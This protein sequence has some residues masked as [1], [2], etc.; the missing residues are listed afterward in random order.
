MTA[1]RQFADHLIAS[2]RDRYG[3]RET[4][5]FVSQLDLATGTLPPA[6]SRFYAGEA[7]RGGAGPT[8]NNLQFDNGLIRLLDALTELGHGERYREAMKAYLDYYFKNL[9]D[10]KTG[11]LPWS[12]HQG[13]AGNQN[14][15]HVAT[16]HGHIPDSWLMRTPRL[17]RNSR[18]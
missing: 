12:D 11:L 9:P 13:Y 5:L 7:H 16:V 4:P 8:S 14:R 1:V 6:T 2:G 3:S 15:I 10:P 18:A 17:V